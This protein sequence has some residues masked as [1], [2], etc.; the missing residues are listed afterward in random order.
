MDDDPFLHRS[1]TH[2]EVRGSSFVY[3]FLDLLFWQF[4]GHAVVPGE[5]EDL[6]PDKKGGMVEMFCDA[7][8][9]QIFQHGAEH[10][11]QVAVSYGL[12]SRIRLLFRS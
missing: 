6:F 1:L 12:D 3:Q 2:D 9:W 11:G 7:Y 10:D 5:S 8:L 4:H